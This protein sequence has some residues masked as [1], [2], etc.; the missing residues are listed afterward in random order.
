MPDPDPDP[1]PV[2]LDLSGWQLRQT[3]SSRTYTFPVG[4]VVQEGGYVVLGRNRAQADFESFWGVTLGESV[5]YRNS[6]DTFV[7][8]FPTVNGDEEKWKKGRFK[9]IAARQIHQMGAILKRA[10][11][12]HDGHFPAIGGWG[13]V[14]LDHR[15]AC[16]LHLRERPQ[17]LIGVLAQSRGGG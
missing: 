3:S 2:T 5:V 4:T 6:A 15:L 11:L 1:G 9:L 7:D 10:L 17:D 16:A 8:Q 12:Q 14:E 13:V